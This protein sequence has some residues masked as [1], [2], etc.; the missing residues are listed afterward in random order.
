MLREL[1]KVP[2]GSYGV[3]MVYLQLLHIDLKYLRYILDK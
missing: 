2:K 3:G 1:D